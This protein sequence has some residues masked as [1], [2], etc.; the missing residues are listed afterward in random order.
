LEREPGGSGL[1]YSFDILR[2]G[3]WR[4]L[5]IDAMTGRILENTSERANPKD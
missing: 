5:G 3:K 2:A 4:E 1:R